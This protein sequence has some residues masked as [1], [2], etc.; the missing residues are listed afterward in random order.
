MP[1]EEIVALASEAKARL[2][3]RHWV[4][5]AAS[6]ILHYRA[7]PKGGALDAE[8]VAH[9]CRFLGWLVEQELPMP[10]AAIVRTPMSVAMDCASW[11]AGFVDPLTSDRRC[12]AARVLVDFLLPIFDASGASIAAVA[13]TGDRVAKLR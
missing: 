1:L 8:S 10:S 5:A 4:L 11:L 3:S 6:L 2:G 12:V 9:G 13:K 7:R